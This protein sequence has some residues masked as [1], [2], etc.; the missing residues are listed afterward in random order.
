M[1]GGHLCVCWDSLNGHVLVT[2][3]VYI[4]RGSMSVRMTHTDAAGGC[5][6]T[7]RSVS[8]CVRHVFKM[9]QVTIKRFVAL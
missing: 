4:A 8:S 2:A 9:K 3:W 1:A 5:V 6:S 7:V